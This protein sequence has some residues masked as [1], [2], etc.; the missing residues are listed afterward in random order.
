MHYAEVIREIDANMKAKAL[1]KEKI[2]TENA[3][4]K[5]VIENM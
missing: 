2:K 3:K 5:P 4:L 1:G